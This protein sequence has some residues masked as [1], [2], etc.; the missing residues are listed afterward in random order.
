MTEDQKRVLDYL[1]S[2]GSSHRDIGDDPIGVLIETNKQ[3]S[4][5]I[6]AERDRANRLAREKS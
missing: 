6:K 3:Q 2:L 5:I 4:F 1:T